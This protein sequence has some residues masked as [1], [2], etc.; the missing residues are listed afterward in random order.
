MKST[1]IAVA[2]TSRQLYLEAIS[3]YYSENTFHF[4]PYSKLS[5]L[6]AEFVAAIG[7]RNASRITAARFPMA[8]S[9][10][11]WCHFSVLPNLEKVRFAPS[12][13]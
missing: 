12:P 2:F 3:I 10:L 13:H 8:Y 4:R 1:L 11:S 5:H 9:T 6:L 7:P